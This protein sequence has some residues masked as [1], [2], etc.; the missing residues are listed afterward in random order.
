MTAARVLIVDGEPAVLPLVSKAIA[1][2]GYEVHAVS[3]WA[4]STHET[5]HPIQDGLNL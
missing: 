5:S 2:W 1:G 4:A 3:S